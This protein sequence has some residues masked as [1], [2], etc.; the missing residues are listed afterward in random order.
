LCVAGTSSWCLDRCPRRRS[1]C[2]SQELGRGAQVVAAAPRRP[3]V[4][5]NYPGSRHHYCCQLG[6]GENTCNFQRL[7]KNVDVEAWS[8]GGLGCFDHH[9]H[10]SRSAVY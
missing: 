9:T 4:A 10:V 3:S 8:S 6:Y 1:L 5:P 2:V 7:L